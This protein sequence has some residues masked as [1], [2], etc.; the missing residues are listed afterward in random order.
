M[1]DAAAEL[2][3]VLLKAAGASETALLGMGKPNVAVM[4]P[5]RWYWLLESV[6]TSFPFIGSDN[7]PPGV[8]GMLESSSE[9]GDGIRGR[10]PGGL[11]ICVDANVPTNKG[12][13]TDEDEIYVWPAEEV[14]VWMEPGA[15]V[16]VR[17]EQPKASA[18]G[19]LLVCYSYFAYLQSGFPKGQR[20]WSGCAVIGMKAP[21]T[22]LS[23][24]KH[25]TVKITAKTL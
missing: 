20:H 21:V 18:L 5:R 10:F 25:T 4:H 23:G 11:N 19:I 22:R 7:L 14:M 3:P 17:A 8:G 6:G 9:Y 16:F 1:G 12:T 13:G 15:P 2:Y 24:G